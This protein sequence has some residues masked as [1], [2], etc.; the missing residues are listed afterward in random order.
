MT[1]FRGVSTPEQRMQPFRQDGSVGDAAVSHVPAS[2][3]QAQAAIPGR[4]ATAHKL[5]AVLGVT[6]GSDVRTGVAP[7]LLE[8]MFVTHG[9]G[10]VLGVATAWA[11]GRVFPVPAG[12]HATRTCFPPGRVQGIQQD[13]TAPSAPLL[14]RWSVRAQDHVRRT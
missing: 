1:Y 3:A 6:P 9:H 10:T 13:P 11:S 12:M 5:L 7:L 2:T 4:S 8:H 14:I